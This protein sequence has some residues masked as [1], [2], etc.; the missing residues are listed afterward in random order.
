MRIIQIQLELCKGQET[1]MEKAG[2]RKGRGAREQIA[3]L[4]DSQ[5]AQGST[6][7]WSKCFKDYTK[8]FESLQYLKMWNGIRSVGITKHL[9][10]LIQDLHTE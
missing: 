1:T 7:K 5:R 6:T 3:N 2:L 9:K 10:V 4:S 8:D